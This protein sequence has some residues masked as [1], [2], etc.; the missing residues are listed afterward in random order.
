LEL[1]T[2]TSLNAS[3]APALNPPNSSATEVKP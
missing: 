3:D 2:G 1:A